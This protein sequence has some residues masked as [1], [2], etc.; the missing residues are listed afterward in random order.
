MAI[1]TGNLRT[2]FARHTEFA[3]KRMD[4]SYQILSSDLSLLDA[5]K[6]ANF[7]YIAGSSN[8]AGFNA[9]IQKLSNYYPT[10][11]G[12]FLNLPQN[13][14]LDWSINK[15]RE[16]IDKIIGIKG[17]ISIKE[18][19]VNRDMPNCLS[20]GNLHKLRS[21]LEYLSKEYGDKIEYLTFRELAQR[22]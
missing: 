14:L 13:V 4:E 3:Y 19:F 12:G 15:M 17:I 9:G 7:K 8:D 22:I 2:F 1:I 16:E 10:V 5:L 20:G 6:M 21:I 18:H 11:I